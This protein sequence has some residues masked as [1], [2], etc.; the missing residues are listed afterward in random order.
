MKLISIIMT[1]H[2]GE[3]YLNDAIL[4]VFKQT[5]SNWELIFI[6]N[7]STDNSRKIICSYND[8]RIKYFKL[9]NTL[10]LGSVRNYAY[11][12]C[13]GDFIS[14]L[15]VDD[16]WFNKKLELQVKKFNSDKSIDILYSNYFKLHNNQNIKIKKSLFKGYCQRN[17]ILS[18]I[19]GKPLTAWLTLMIKKDR[20]KN[21][22]YIFDKNIHIASDFDLII[23][24]SSNCY[25]D[26]VEE[27]ICSYR[28]HDSNE[29]KQ[30]VKELREILYIINKYKK[31]KKV[32]KILSTD[33][34][35][36]KILFKYLFS[37]INF[38]NKI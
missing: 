11:T 6:D 35:Y 10:N 17:I 38:L 18:Y 25:F 13:L 7:N 2:N 29:S 20:L 19:N 32:A 36:F 1:C 15:D 21:L 37:K 26:F 34:F 33:F 5:Y 3:K 9:E 12:K 4:S 8:K 30:P 16:L 14:F 27:Y 24:L 23:R 31:N 28:V 22:E